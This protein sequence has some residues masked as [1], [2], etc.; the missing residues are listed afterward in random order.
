MSNLKGVI[1]GF[2]CIALFGLATKPFRSVAR[3]YQVDNTLC[4]EAVEA[5]MGSYVTKCDNGRSYNHVLGVK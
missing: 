5:S 4:R 1:L 2:V 3:T